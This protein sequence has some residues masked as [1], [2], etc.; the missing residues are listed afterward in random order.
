[1][2]KP[3]IASSRPRVLNRADRDIVALGIATAAL[4]LFIGTGG[5]L[6]PQIVRSWFGMGAAPDMLL[7][8][9]VLL[10][11]AL[12]IFGWRRYNELHHEIGER[13]KAEERARELAEIDPLTGCHNRRSGA[14]AIDL[15]CTEARVRQREVAVLMVDL[16]NFK[17]I[18][19]LNGHKTGDTVLVEVAERI[20]RL[21][22]EDGIVARIG[23][24]EFLCAVSYEPGCA[25]RIDHIAG[26]HDPRA[27]RRY[28]D[29][30]RQEAGPEPLLL[31]RAADGERTALPRRARVGHPPRHPGR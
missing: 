12:L 9:A 8:N 17:Q 30:P 6:M 25:N 20:R 26:Q 15:L 16:D 28:R 23:G 5:S 2:S 7:T 24:D 1:L 27:S 31:V 11:I 13:R 19:D 29:V 14:P 3:A 21:L 10:N 22:P 4:I 18:N